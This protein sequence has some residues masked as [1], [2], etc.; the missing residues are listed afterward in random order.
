MIKGITI[1]S[2]W[3][4]DQ[5]AAKAFY[6]Q[7]L[8]F[9]V[10]TDVD[11]DNGMRW[12]TIRPPGNPGQDLLLMEAA[13]SML[14]PDTA[15]QVRALVAKGALSPGVMGTTDCLAD[16]ALLAGRGVP[17]VQPPAQR[18]YGVEAVMR[19]DSGTGSA[20][21]S[22]RAPGMDCD[23][24]ASAPPG[25]ALCPPAP[26]AL[27]R[28]LAAPPVGL[29]RRRS[30]PNRAPCPRNRSVMAMPIGGHRPVVQMSARRSTPAAKTTTSTPSPDESH[31]CARVR[32]PRSMSGGPGRLLRRRVGHVGQDQ[33]GFELADARGLPLRLQ[34]TAGRDGGAQPK[35][36][37]AHRCRRWRRRRRS[38]AP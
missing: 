15:A 36:A 31:P 26:V 33:V 30:A 8:G 14:D 6:V 37:V 25:P 32:R 13:H 10:T 3:V 22:A 4:L 24:L 1:V 12:L 9:E 21:Q 11:L 20:S 29:S 27:S 35:A 18:P 16:H 2:L 38:D 5:V 34:R 7:R 17:F 19:D 23:G 28:A